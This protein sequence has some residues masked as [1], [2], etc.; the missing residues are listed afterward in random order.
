MATPSEA[1]FDSPL[2]DDLER[3]FPLATLGA[4]DRVGLFRLA[5]DVA[6]SGFGNRQ[7]LYERFLFGPPERMASAFYGIYDKTP[8]VDR[9]HEFL[10]RGAT[11]PVES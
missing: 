1:D 4:R 5:H 3:Y 2:A 10:H 11:D 9:I 6:A 7:L 8:L